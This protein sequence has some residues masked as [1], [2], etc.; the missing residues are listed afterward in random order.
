MS[1]LLE[2]LFEARSVAVVG[3]STRTGSFG[4]RLATAV[5][6]SGFRGRIDLINPRG[7]TV[8]ERPC[9]EHLRDL[10]TPPDVALLGVGAG[11]LERAL[12]DAI[13]AG[14][15]SA[16]IY[17]A[18]AGTDGTGAPLLQRLKDIAREADLPVCGGNGMGF[19]NVTSG[20]CGSFYPAGHLKPG[21]ISLIAHSGSV[22]T[23]LALNDPRFRFDLVASPG[24]EIGATLDQ[25][26]DYASGRPTT[27]AIAVFM[28]SAR[29]PDGLIES[30]KT[31]RD[32][33]VPVI[34]CKVGRTAESARLAQSHTGALAGSNEAY[35][36]VFDECG[37]ISVDSI[38]RLMNTAVLC[39]SGRVPGPG[40][41]AMV[42]DSGGLREMQIDLAASLKAPLA[43]LS[44]E[45]Q[46]KLRAALPA[47]LEPSNPLDCA[48]N[49]TAE[50][51]KVFDRGLEI[52]AAA[53][54]VSILG[55]EAD[56]RDDYIYHDRVFAQAET[57]AQRTDK[58]CFF[59]SSFGQ[60]H[61]RALGDRLADLDVP[62]INGAEYALAAARDLQAWAN[63]R[64]TEM[65]DREP[66]PGLP[67]DRLAIWQARLSE[68]H[69]LGETERLAL[70]AELGMDTVRSFSEASAEGIVDAA[71]RLGYPVALKT[72]EAGIDH[73]SDIGGVVLD[74]EDRGHLLNAYSDIAGRLGPR[75]TVQRMASPGVELAFGC[76]V[77][78]DFGAVV[79]VSAGGT[80]VEL[81]KDR[82]FA[83]APVPS[84]RA[85]TMI[86]ALPVARTI[87]GVRGTPRRDMT[88]AAQALSRFSL[89]CAALQDVVSEIDIN[90]VVISESGAIAVD[91]LIVGV[92]PAIGN[93]AE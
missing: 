29:D 56:M 44:G 33:N 38:D 53:P 17:D 40:G 73:K 80:L 12:E 69:G 70:F 36:A 91:A 20:L 15:R 46:A 92:R 1:H 63:R 65:P 5:L 26:I 6:G 81:F 90:P 31:A 8:R 11:N 71:N 77:D 62:C 32:R 61:N 30:L 52:L 78:P 48:S 76:I 58:P 66:L 24:Q 4:E 19:L 42:G 7:G 47:E 28:E 35:E 21:G 64:R 13:D 50:F 2:P 60:A 79:M 88:G 9:L 59:F 45:T 41:L 85:E 54:E 49:L 16:V 87:D 75:V 57:L 82:R 23:V 89:I 93:A 27:R 18:C 55:F 86:R 22:F 72:A 74:I 14:A 10:A 84:A 83:R 68:G 39:A 34:V 67:K 3:A 25:Y 51:P 43:T 37:A